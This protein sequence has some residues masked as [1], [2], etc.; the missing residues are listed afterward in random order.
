[1][2]IH[3]ESKITWWPILLYWEN[4]NVFLCDLSLAVEARYL[5]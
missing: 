4:K 5:A 1:M 3:F 2:Y